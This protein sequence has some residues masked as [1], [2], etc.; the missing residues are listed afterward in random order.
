MMRC[1]KV[2]VASWQES[3]G[4][5]SIFPPHYVKSGEIIQETDWKGSLIQKDVVQ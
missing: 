3:F 5:V 1:L 2:L 4:R